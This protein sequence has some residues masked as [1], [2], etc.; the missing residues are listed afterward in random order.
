MFCFQR[1][2]H[3]IVHIIMI[4]VCTTV[5]MFVDIMSIF[6]VRVLCFLILK[7]SQQVL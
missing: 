7:E 4:Y 2:G 1:V 3:I 6:Q 5:C